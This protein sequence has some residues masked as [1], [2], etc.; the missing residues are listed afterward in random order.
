MSY[1]APSGSGG[2]LLAQ[3][4]N[5]AGTVAEAWRNVG[6]RQRRVDQAAN[7]PLNVVREHAIRDLWNES[8]ASADAAA[9]AS[10]PD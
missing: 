9:E 8:S 10:G 4:R 7:G 1:M 6:E 2:Q 5:I 3:S